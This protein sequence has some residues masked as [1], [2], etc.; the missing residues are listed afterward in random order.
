MAAGQ[1]ARVSGCSC[2]YSHSSSDPDS[3]PDLTCGIHTVIHVAGPQRETIQHERQCTS[4]SRM[5]TCLRNYTRHCATPLQQELF[6]LLFN[7]IRRVKHEY[8]APDSELRSLYLKHVPCIRSVVRDPAN[9]CMKDMQ[10]LGEVVTE[11]RWNKRADYACCGYH[12]VGRCLSQQVERACGDE[13]SDFGKKMLRKIVSR[14]PEIRC[15]DL[16]EKSAVCRE[17]PPFGSSPKGGQSTSVINK[18]IRTY[19]SSSR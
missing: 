19:T 6:N 2:S 4:L 14:L 9:P 18:L 5:D 15:R 3:L 12:R 8:C 7:G 10:V 11:A 16:T 1:E 13:T 17:L